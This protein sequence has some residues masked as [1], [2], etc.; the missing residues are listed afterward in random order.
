MHSRKTREELIR[1]MIHGEESEKKLDE[2]V[3]ILLEEKFALNFLG[4][5]GQKERFTE[6]LS[7]AFARFTGS[8]T[9]IILFTVMMIAWIGINIIFLSQP[10]DPYPFILLNLFLSCISSIQAPIIMMSQN[11]QAEK[12]RERSENEYSINLK[13]EI[14][15]EDMHLK[16]EDILRNQERLLGERP[17]EKDKTKRAR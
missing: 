12:D 15:L 2:L 13:A 5:N 3:D 14:M 11:R 17:S 6:R 16:L 10:F 7:D 1:Q 4:R 8:W 9:F